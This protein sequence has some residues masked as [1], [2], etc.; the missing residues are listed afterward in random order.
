MWHCR[1]AVALC[2][3]TGWLDGPESQLAPDAAGLT[4]AGVAA[5]SGAA[6]TQE[7]RGLAENFQTGSCRM[8][9]FMGCLARS[10]RLPF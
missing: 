6:G 10:R 1:V 5:A 7:P 2:V 9:L 8:P 3:R 4:R